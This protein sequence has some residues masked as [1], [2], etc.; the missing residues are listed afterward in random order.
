M[1]LKELINA[2]ITENQLEILLNRGDLKYNGLHVTSSLLE[3][4]FPTSYIISRQDYVRNLNKEDNEL[5]WTYWSKATKSGSLITHHAF[6]DFIFNPE[7]RELF[8]YAS[9]LTAINEHYLIIN[10]GYK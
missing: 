3:L 4:E 6:V 10:K 9:A 5:Y 2:V 8:K 7:I 1:T